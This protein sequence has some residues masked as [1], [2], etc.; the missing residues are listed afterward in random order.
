MKIHFSKQEK[1]NCWEQ[2]LVKIEGV[3]L[4]QFYVISN[5][6]VPKVS[7]IGSIIIFQHIWTLSHSLNFKSRNKL[8]MKF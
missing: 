5:T 1:K 3:T 8:E 6:A 4:V 7:K 2:H